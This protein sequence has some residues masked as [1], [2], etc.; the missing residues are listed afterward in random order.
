MPRDTEPVLK[1]PWKRERHDQSS[2]RFRK[3][4]VYDS[5][6]EDFEFARMGCPD[7]ARSAEAA[8]MDLPIASRTAS[9]T[10]KIST[11]PD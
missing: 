1:Y 9:T 3:F 4:G 2:Q 6:L 5:D 11:R 10:Y 8:I 7:G